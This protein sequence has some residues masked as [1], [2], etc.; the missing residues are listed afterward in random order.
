[1]LEKIKDK[2]RCIKITFVICIFILSL[3]WAIIQPDT[4]APDEIMKM[5]ICRYIAENGKLPH[6]GDEAIRDPSWGIS[7]AFSPI[8][9][10]IIGGGFIKIVSFFTQEL[11]IYYIA[12]RL[13]SVICY[14]IMTIF[15]IKIGEKLFPKKGTK[16]MFIMLTTLLPQV[17]F[18]GSYINNDSLALLSISIII[19]SWIIG[20]ETKWNIKSCVGLAIG[21]GV[22]ALSY[23]NAYG[24]ILTSILI[25]VVTYMIDEKREI[26][27][28][29]KKGIMISA[30][31]ILIFGWWFIRSAIIYNGDFLGLRTTDEYA[32]KYA[33]EE[34]KPSKRETPVNAGTG[35]LNMLFERRWIS[36]TVKSFIG[37]F[38]GMN[39]SMRIE[40]YIIYIVIFGM[41][42]IGYFL[43]F[44]KL[45]YRKQL[46]RAKEKIVLEV[47]FGLNIIIAIALSVIY[48][49]YS[50]FQPQGRYIMPML[51]PFMYFV[52]TGLENIV[53]VFIKNEK[54]Q[55][56]IKMIVMLLII[57]V[58][59]LALLRIIQEYLLK[60][61]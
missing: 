39:I 22:C 19:Y 41:G 23:Y 58:S 42:I 4:S 16:W 10:Y 13:V 21:I 3:T 36:Q 11:H 60:M 46:K 27:D 33:R 8:L 14:T 28:F 48:S 30:I 12:A 9:S 51:I 55:K 45:E 59:V 47:M 34:L 61:C 6:G 54:L 2:E 50:D 29:V 35:L 17:T 49:Y 1:M 56:I 32:E 44:S 31:S 25:F 53:E 18:L 24:F 38:G 26:K 52:A 20:L 37:V 5:D 15:V 57:L 43:K 40:S 7:Y